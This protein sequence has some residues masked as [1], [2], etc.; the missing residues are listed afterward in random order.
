MFLPSDILFN[1]LALIF[2]TFNCFTPPYNNFSNIN[3][4]NN[5]VTIF[6]E[7]AL[8][9]E[10]TNVSTVYKLVL[11]GDTS[12]SNRNVT[13]STEQAKIVRRQLDFW[14]YRQYIPSQKV[15]CKLSKHTV[16]VCK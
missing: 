9:K 6:S 1:L 12:T 4:L 16:F 5:Y 8:L 14:K 13:F 2:K 10:S 7:S 11:P 3:M 15:H